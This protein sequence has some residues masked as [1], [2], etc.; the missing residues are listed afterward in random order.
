MGNCFMAGSDLVRWELI[1]LGG[2]GPYRLAVHHAKGSI[3]E[4]FETVADALAR[5]GQLETLLIAART[6]TALVEG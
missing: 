6:G 3:V 2:A 5:E 1:A 4:Y